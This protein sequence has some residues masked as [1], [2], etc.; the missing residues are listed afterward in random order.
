MLLLVLLWVFKP[1]LPLVCAEP[2][3]VEI[4]ESGTFRME[5]TRPCNDF[6]QYGKCWPQNLPATVLDGN[7]KKIAVLP[8]VHYSHYH[9]FEVRNGEMFWLESYG[10]EQKISWRL[11]AKEIGDGGEMILLENCGGEFRISPDGNNVISISSVGISMLDRQA[12]TVMPL[13]RLDN[14]DRD[15]GFTPL[16]WSSDGTKF[17]FGAGVVDHWTKLGL[18]EGG[19]VS[20]LAYEGSSGDEAFEPDRGWLVTSDAPFNYDADT[21]ED[22]KKENR[23]TRLIVEDVLAGKKAVL[24]K[25]NANHYGPFWDRNG[26][27]QYSINGKT[28][29]VSKEKIAEKLKRP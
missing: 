8:M 17:W 22:W 2:S 24:A 3:L 18:F 27:L 6:S 5:A 16:G 23:P 25:A 4:R 29:K 7:G 15:D 11:W 1:F 19:K 9:P 10:D 26:F 20:W 14:T 21:E 28:F 12:G 13:V